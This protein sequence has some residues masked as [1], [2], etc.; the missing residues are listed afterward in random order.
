M[1]TINK[2][3]YWS[4]FADDFEEMQS[5]VV[6]NEILSLIS[7]ELLKESEL[8]Y[9]LELGCGTGL[10]TESLQKISD[11]VL[12]TDFSEEMIAKAQQKRGHLE[13]VAFQKADALNLEFE[14]KIFDT[15]YMAN[16]IHIIGNA[17][18][19]VKESKR[20]LNEGGLLIIASFAIN[21]MNFLSKIAMGIRYIRK[22]GKP[23]TD[24]VKE[25]TTA[26]SVEQI[27]VN[28]GFEIKKSCILGHKSKAFYI[29]AINK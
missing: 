23:S 15:V 17:E 26:K 20:V 6:G 12:A 3:T 7:L 16:L 28:S 18:L 1:E 8:G 29:S 21:E 14:E 25:K 9:V 22:F 5:Q 27:L 2:E 19:A 11:K 24:A 13:N 4:R 10:Y